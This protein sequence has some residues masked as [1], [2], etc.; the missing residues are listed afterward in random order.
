MGTQ[1]TSITEVMDVLAEKELAIKFIKDYKG[2]LPDWPKIHDDFIR[3]ELLFLI[4]SVADL[5]DAAKR[6]IDEY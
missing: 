1:I 2:F 6:K 5:C 3:T 4:G